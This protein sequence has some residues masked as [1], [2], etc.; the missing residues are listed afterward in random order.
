MNLINSKNNSNIKDLVKIRDDSKF[1][2]DKSLF[3]IEGERIFNTSIKDSIDNYS[4]Y[5]TTMT[6]EGITVPE[7]YREKAN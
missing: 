6:D 2:N 7:R 4:N 1:R 5:S 3:Y